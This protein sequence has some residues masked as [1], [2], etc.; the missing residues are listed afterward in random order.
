MNYSSQENTINRRR[1]RVG[2]V[3]AR[4]GP[5]FDKYFG[6]NSDTQCRAYK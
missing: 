5:K 3:Q 4:L 6:P 1:S 2:F